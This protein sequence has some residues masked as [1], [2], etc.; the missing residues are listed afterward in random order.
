M[1][2]KKYALA[3]V[4]I[5]DP[6][7]V[8]AG[9]P[10]KDIKWESYV[11]CT[12]SATPS[13]DGSSL[14]LE[15][16]T[17]STSLVSRK[18]LPLSTLQ[19]P[20]RR[21]TYTDKQAAFR[22]DWPAE[23]PQPPNTK[24]MQECFQ[25]IFKKPT[26]LIALLES[27]GPF[28]SATPSTIKPITL[29]VSQVPPS[30]S[31]PKATL[32]KSSAAKKKIAPKP[33]SNGKKGDGGDAMTVHRVGGPA[34]PSA[35]DDNRTRPA[36][37]TTL[38]S[39]NQGPSRTPLTP[40]SLAL[41]Q[42][43][44]QQ[45][46][47][48]VPL[49]VTEI[50][51]R[52]SPTRPPSTSTSSALSTPLGGSKTTFPEDPDMASLKRKLLAGPGLAS[53]GPKVAHSKFPPARLAPAP[54]VVYPPFTTYKPQ[55]ADNA[56]SQPQQPSSQLP[57]SMALV[58]PPTSPNLICLS[59]PLISTAPSPPRTALKSNPLDDLLDLDSSCMEFVPIMTREQEELET[60]RRLEEEDLDE[61]YTLPNDGN[62]IP[63][64]HQA[65]QATVALVV[66]FGS[67]L[68]E[69]GEEDMDDL[70]STCMASDGFDLLYRKVSYLLSR[71]D[72]LQLCAPATPSLGASFDLDDMPSSRVLTPPTES[73]PLSFFDQ[74]SAFSQDRSGQYYDFS[75]TDTQPSFVPETPGY[76]YSSKRS[77]CGDISEY[78]QE[79][80]MRMCL[81]EEEEE[82]DVYDDLEEEDMRL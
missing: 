65:F 49:H 44:N 57:S 14:Q 3:R 77:Y 1:P 25:L 64:A 20:F 81:E 29:T 7:L 8:P 70:I 45:T 75:Q 66:A 2:E 30:K 47:P 59:S 53:T 62:D 42:A 11:H 34:N 63:P 79:K 5:C 26:D 13:P 15:M 17:S 78:D 60:K 61:E 73:Y 19:S 51:P 80:R 21:I 28:F 58:K 35:V 32:K 36:D 6:R 16:R 52:P 72:S 71:R 48:M 68:H 10:P 55:S 82:E 33:K 69:L 4:S 24:T 43:G 27:L 74:P 37:S 54:S 22:Y 18:F 40:S 31:A 23:S 12:I 56:P 76:S 38:P 9:T 39:S 41:N 67:P 50:A 46:R